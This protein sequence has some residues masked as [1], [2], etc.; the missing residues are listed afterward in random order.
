MVEFFVG[1]KVIIFVYCFMI[2]EVV[3][4]DC[5]FFSIFVCKRFG[6]CVKGL[7]SG[8]YVVQQK[9]ICG[10]KNINSNMYRGRSLCYVYICVELGFI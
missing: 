2:V 6:E 10:N 3:L 8:E 4:F 1:G 9:N 7:I 5:F